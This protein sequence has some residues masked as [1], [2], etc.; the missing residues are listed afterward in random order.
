[1]GSKPGPA[2]PYYSPSSAFVT[3]LNAAGQLVY[4]TYLGGDG[5][6]YANAIAVDGAGEAHV[7]GI[8]HASDFPTLHALQTSL[9]GKLATA[10][11]TKLNAAG[12]ALVY[13]TYFGSGQEGQ[14]NPFGFVD[15]GFDFGEQG[16]A[17]ALDGAG[18]AYVTGTIIVSSVSGIGDDAFVTK[19]GPAGDQ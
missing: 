9:E 1:Q 6:T 15:V 2:G 19:F 11:V 4:S 10:F 16:N 7:T 17:I 14:G 3:K 18:N 5:Y 12:N 13:S 8:T